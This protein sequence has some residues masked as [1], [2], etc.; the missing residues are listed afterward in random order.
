MKSTSPNPVKIM[1]CI[2][3]RSS[4]ENRAAGQSDGDGMEIQRLV[5]DVWRCSM[6]TLTEV[7]FPEA[8]DRVLLESDHVA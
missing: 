6:P 5:C 7:S 8:F 1:I 4:P 2:F 3:W